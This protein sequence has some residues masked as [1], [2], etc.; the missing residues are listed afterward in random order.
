[1][2]GLFKKTAFKIWFS[3]AVILLAI[4]TVLSAKKA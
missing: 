3:V 4:E 2:K 1:M